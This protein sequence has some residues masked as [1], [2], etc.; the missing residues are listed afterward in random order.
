MSLINYIWSCSDSIVG[1]SASSRGRRVPAV[2]FEDILDILHR[3][4]M[5]VK[6]GF[7]ALDKLPGERDPTHLHRVLVIALHLACLLVKTMGNVSESRKMTALKVNKKHA[8]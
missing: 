4:I 2:A 6:N 8:D 3:A 7:L 1:R 5:E